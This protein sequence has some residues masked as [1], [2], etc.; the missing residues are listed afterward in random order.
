MI[1]SR[2]TSARFSSGFLLLLSALVTLTQ[3][4]KVASATTTVKAGS[5][6]LYSGNT[7]ACQ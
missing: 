3:V 1:K 5:I 4:G 6:S 7:G 2:T